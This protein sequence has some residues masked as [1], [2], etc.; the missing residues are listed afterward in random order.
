MKLPGPPKKD[1]GAKP[2][3]DNIPSASEQSKPKPGEV[4]YR[5]MASN[6]PGLS[7]KQPFSK[8]QGKPSSGSFPGTDQG[9]PQFTGKQINPGR[10]L[11]AFEAASKNAPTA[12]VPWRYRLRPD[13]ELTRRAYW[14]VAATFSLIV[15]IFLLFLLVLMAGQIRNLKITVDTLLGGV[16]GNIA[17]MDQASIKTNL[18]V[19][20]QIPLDFNLPVSQNT[21][22]VLNS[23]VNIPNAHLVI[24]TGIINI[25]TQANITL[26]AGTTLPIALNLNIPVQYTIP[27][28]LQ[29]PVNIPLSQTEL[30]VPLTGLQTSLNPLTCMLNQDAQYPD[31]IYLCAEHDVPAPGTP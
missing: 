5:G 27:I 21:Q 3:A 20:A 12:R 1:Q 15:N 26:P 31:G 8:P 22:V 13:G 6:R 14:D 23:D 19:N 4:V 18:L 7:G 24:N 2:N 9:V 28:S 30:H 11:Q 25:N 29:V 16:Y 17:K 10:R